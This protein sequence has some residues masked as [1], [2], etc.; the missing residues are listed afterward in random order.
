[1]NVT[2]NNYSTPLH[3]AA[4][5]GDVKVCE[6]LLDHKARINALDITQSTPLH[7]AAAFN[8]ADVIEFLLDR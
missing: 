4:V 3:L 2:R 7:K 8:H 1:M 6:L 5:A